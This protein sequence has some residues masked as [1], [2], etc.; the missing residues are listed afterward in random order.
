MSGRW[1]A[2]AAPPSLLQVLLA[3]HCGVVFLQCSA[4]SAMSGDGECC[5][6]L[7]FPFFIFHGEFVR[8]LFEFLQTQFAPRC[9]HF[10]KIRFSFFPFLFSLLISNG[11]SV[12]AS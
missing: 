3:L 11:P 10:W 12:F 9:L 5:F 2:A 4:A 7:F 6:L 8:F 1:A